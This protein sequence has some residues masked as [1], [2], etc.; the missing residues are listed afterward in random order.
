MKRVL[1]ALL[2]AVLLATAVCAAHADT[3]AYVLKT[4]QT[5]QVGSIGGEWAVI[6]LAR[7]ETAVPQS[8]YD[9]YLQRLTAHVQQCGGVLDARKY[10]EYSRVILALTALGKDAA[11]FA[12]YDLTLPLSDFDATMKQGLNGAIWALIAI[13]SGGYP[14]AVRQKYVDEIVSR[15]HADGGWSLSKAQAASDPDVTAM[16]LQALAKYRWQTAADKAVTAGVSYLAGADYT[17]SE[18]LSQAAIALCEL[19]QDP[20]VCLEKLSAYALPDG[21]FRH[22][23]DGEANEMATEQALLALAAAARLGAGKTSLYAIDCAAFQDV[24]GHPD[25]AA[26]ASLAARG[27]VNGKAQYRF[28]PDGTMTRAEFAAIMT[29]A[30]ELKQQTTD[31]FSDVAPAAWYAPYIGAAYEAGIIAGRGGGIFDPNGAIT[32]QEAA[33]MVARAAKLRGMTG[34]ASLPETLT[35][36]AQIAPWAVDS[37]ALCYRDDILTETTFE[38]LRAIRRCEVARMLYRLLVNDYVVEAS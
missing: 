8:W 22:T 21:S 33:V 11:S 24:I 23:L 1:S 15:Q 20:A 35:D 27:I 18:S 19:G 32:R 14:C 4:V 30:M 31:A 17:S 16:A 36:A 10:T 34:G 7:S 12:G 3:A 6:G 5:P 2:I 25:E 29:R 28:D 9:G 13:D 26:I 37:V 38:P